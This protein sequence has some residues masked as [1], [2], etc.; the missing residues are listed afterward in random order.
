MIA[1][2]PFTS[3]QGAIDA[4]TT[5]EGTAD[6]LITFWVSQG[7]PFTSGHIVHAIRTA[8]SDLMFSQSRIGAHVRRMHAQG[9]MPG[10]DDGLGNEIPVQFSLRQTTGIGRTPVGIEVCV[11]APSRPEAD[12]F[13]FEIN[14]AEAPQVADGQGGTTSAATAM[15]NATPNLPAGSP[16]ASPIPPVQPSGTVAVAYGKMVPGNPLATIHSDGRLCIPR[17]AFEALAHETG[18]PIKGG[19][20]LYVYETPTDLIVSQSPVIDMPHQSYAPTTD[21]LRLH[22]FLSKTYPVGTDFEVLVLSNHL[23]I[24]LP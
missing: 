16:G 6:N 11:Y 17:L 21:R 20:S 7:V 3:A 8:R 18:D 1:Q 24:S 12:L 9:G 22:L 5:P 15:L 2:T 13:E 23:S 19:E 4:A 10:Y 14:I